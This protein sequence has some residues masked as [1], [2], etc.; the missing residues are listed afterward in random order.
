M[1]GDPALNFVDTPAGLARLVDDLLR[2]S[3]VAIDT[4]SNSLHAHRERV[5]LI[6]ISTGSDD[7]LVDPLALDDLSPL[8]AVIG[9][10]SVEKVFHAAEYDLMCLRR[11]FDF[12]FVS[13]FDTMV[14]ARILGWKKVGLA[15]VLE[16]EFSVKVNKRHQR[17]DWGARPLSTDMLRYAQTD[18]HYLLALRK[19]LQAELE[20]SGRMEEA[21]EVFAELVTVGPHIA[22]FDPDAFWNING[23]HRLK[24]HQQA[25]LR[26]L[27]LYRERMAEQRD[28]PPFKVMEEKRLLELAQREPGSIR[29]LERMGTLSEWQVRKYGRGILRSVERGRKAKVPKQPRQRRPDDAVLTRFDALRD[30]RKARARQRGVES[31]VVMTKD[32]LWILARKAPH[33][34]DE[35]VA[36]GKPGPW[37]RKTYGKEI[38][39]VLNQSDG[40]CH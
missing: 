35:L 17:A 32:D 33:T 4:E 13:L 24:G 34:Q 22:E 29:Q 18:T 39:A 3:L 20:A 30:W 25:I 40:H 28:V 2:E 27:Y 31:D 19:L 14:A 1:S 38:L 6:Q 9:E 21:Q 26:E 8:E 11:D 37:K 36:I 15:S 10:P 5:C 12:G 16:A 23:M 7:Y